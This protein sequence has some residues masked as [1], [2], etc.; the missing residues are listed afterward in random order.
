MNEDVRMKDKDLNWVTVNIPNEKEIEWETTEYRKYYT[1]KKWE[2]DLADRMWDECPKC[3]SQKNFI[4]KDY[5]GSIGTTT[6][7]EC[8]DCHFEQDITNFDWW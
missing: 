7:L 6:I 1:H 8:Q 5:G 2:K 4:R 3:K